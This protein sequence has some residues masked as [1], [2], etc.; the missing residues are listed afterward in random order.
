M[1]FAYSE[2]YDQSTGEIR[3]P[4]TEGFIRDVFEKL[5][6]RSEEEQL[7]GTVGNA[8]ELVRNLA[9]GEI[10]AVAEILACA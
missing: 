8:Y 9:A 5:R 1:C 7:A 4:S 10:Q 2:F 3:L 6:P